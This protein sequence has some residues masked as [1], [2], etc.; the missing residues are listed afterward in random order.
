MG[1][2]NETP[3]EILH[4]DGRVIGYILRRMGGGGGGRGVVTE[5]KSQV[6]VAQVNVGVLLNSTDL[7]LVNNDQSQRY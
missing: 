1:W 6:R 4:L 2:C 3:M 7:Q 5:I